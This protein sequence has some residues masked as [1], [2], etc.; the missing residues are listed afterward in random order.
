MHVL[1]VGGGLGGLSLAQCFRKQGI[2]FEIFERDINPDSRF[3]GWAIAIHSIIDELAQAFP[4]D[5]PDLKEA[6]DH[7]A[8]LDLPAQIG[9]YFPGREGRLGVQ[10]TPEAPIVRAERR[11]LRDWLATNLPIQWGK[12]VTRVEHDDE[13]VSVYFDDGTNA[14]GD[15]LVGAD[16]INSV[17]REHLLQRSSNDLLK[18]VPIAAIVGEVT[19]SGEAFKHQLE[20]GHSAYIFVKPDLGFWNFGGLHHVLPDGVSGRHYW[21]F[22]QRD[23]DVASP[24]HWLQTATQQEKLDHVMK[25]VAKLPP[26]F[27]EIFELT[28]VGG[29]KKESHIWRDL[30]LNS[31]PAGRVILMGDA[32]H[33]M[34]PFRGEGGYHTLIDAMKL[35]KILGQLDVK[36][37]RAVRAAVT[38]YN[39]EMLERGSEAVRNSRNEQP[40]RSANQDVK[41]LPE[42]QI[43]LKVKA[44]A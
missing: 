19:L 30:E 22:M 11:R 13:G 24:D 44:V 5:M 4:A 27:R 21:M 7:L 32:A 34:T 1:I 37:I 40:A 2:S 39:T 3:Q 26:K 15:I 12:R 35:S 17:V 43:V 36:D 25:A 20:L 41:P 38:E 14:K 33:T 6:T 29:I 16:G 8:P 31:L 23:P 9:L 28:P 42:E 18:L 10:S